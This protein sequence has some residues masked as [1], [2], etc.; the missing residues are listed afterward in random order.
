MKRC[1]KCNRAES[2]DSLAY[3]RADG[4]HLVSDGSFV[5]ESAGTLRFGSAPVTGETGT[6]ILPTGEAPSRPTAPTTVID[7]Q[8]ATGGTQKLSKPKSRRGVVAAVV[9]VAVLALAASVYLYLSRD[10]SAAAKN[11][12]AVLP[13]QNASGDPNL[14]Y[15]SDGITE[16]IINSLSQLSNVRVM[17][18]TTMF[19]FKGKD[20]D[21]RA[22]GKQLG[23]V[24]VLTGRVVQRG[25]SLT[26]QADLVNVSDGSQMWGEQYNRKLTDLMA[27]QG[28]VARDV[29]NKLRT[30]LSGADEQKLAKTYTANPEAYQFYLKGLFYW[31]KR[32]LKDSEIAARYLQQATAADPSF[33]PAFAGL[34]DS[35]ATIA[36]FEGGAPAHE[37][38]PKARDA[39]LTA[40]VLDDR[41][42]E[43]HTALGFILT[44]YDYDFAGAEREFKLAVELNPNYADA[45]QRYSLLLTS[46]G[47]HEETFTEMRR[48]LEIDPLSVFS[49]RAY[50]NRLIDARRYDEAIVQLKK[51]LELDSNFA[52]AY[53]SLALVYQAQS[54]YAASVE[55]IAKAYELTGRQEYAALARESFA[56][57]GWQGYLRAMMERRPELFAYTRAAYHA[58]LGEKDKAFAELDKS[59]ENREPYLIRLKVDPRLDP[60]RSDPRFAELMRKVG[61]PQ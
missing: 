41:S 29:S 17:A 16:N 35:Y 39:A 18:R 54:D 13:F 1:P 9:V 48:A 40:L 21:P 6:R 53:S 36:L 55:A 56:K 45:H 58:A 31:N 50:G 14:E 20:A 38:M 15:L 2:D 8:Q 4:T 10:K 19:S 34:A 61:L 33:A 42:A 44:N 25:D 23:V 3:C 59:Y 12:I 47:R 37:V 24:A 60:L 5:S 52:L 32:T 49:N 28:E 51:T 46:L 43:A 57:G 26:I 11:S 7:K 27:L 30:K 22:I